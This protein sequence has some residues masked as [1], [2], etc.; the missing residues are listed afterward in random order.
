MGIS[1]SLN[2]RLCPEPKCG[3]DLIPLGATVGGTRLWGCKSCRRVYWEPSTDQD[4]NQV[5][6]R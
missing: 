6:K 3:G 2:L 5:I 4:K 1:G